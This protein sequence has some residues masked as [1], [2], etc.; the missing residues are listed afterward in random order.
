MQVLT[1]YVLLQQTCLIRFCSG[2][3]D[4]ASYRAAVFSSDCVRCWVFVESGHIILLQTQRHPLTAWRGE[5][6][7][8]REIVWHHFLLASATG[9]A[10]VSQQQCRETPQREGLYWFEAKNNKHFAPLGWIK[11]Y[12]GWKRRITTIGTMAQTNKIPTDIL[13][14]E[15]WP[16]MSSFE[17]IW[18]ICYVL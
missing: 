4:V 3:Q 9:A 8:G 6:P 11:G 15:E 1:I 16:K 7:M 14:R 10:T 2:L 18:L 17:K 5:R 12:M 13:E